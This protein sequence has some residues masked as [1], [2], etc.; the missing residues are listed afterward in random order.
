M[1]SFAAALFATAF[2]A[3]DAEA[4]NSKSWTG[5]AAALAG[6]NVTPSGSSSWSISS[7]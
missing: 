1:K 4:A 2:L 6:K 7:S 5:T 3:G